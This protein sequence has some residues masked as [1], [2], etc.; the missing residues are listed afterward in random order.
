MK[1]RKN[2]NVVSSGLALTLLI[3]VG[4]PFQLYSLESTNT[5]VSALNGKVDLSYGN[6]DS[7][8]GHALGGS[9]SLPVGNAFGFQADGLYA[10]IDRIQLYGVGAHFFWRQNERGLIGLNVGFVDGEAQQSRQVAIETEYYWN[11]LTLAMMAG[12]SSI[13]YDN[14]A[15]FVDTDMEQFLGSV[16]LGYYAMDNLLITLGYENRFHQGSASLGAEY[17]LPLSGVSLYLSALKGE[18]DYEQALVGIRVAFGGGATL[19]QRHRNDDPSNM[20]TGILASIGNYGS[21]YY[22]KS[23]ESGYSTGE[24]DASF[25]QSS[26]NRTSKVPA[27]KT[28]PTG[29]P[30]TLPAPPPVPTI[31]IPTISVPPMPTLS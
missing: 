14:H 25:G 24:I 11:N 27:G 18:N 7:N 21:E 17:G 1:N 9:V 4:L 5:A 2:I 8:T 29:L 16:Q 20:L 10:N 6:Y 13:V 31:P 23:R 22:R 15:P 26:E 12:M 28:V 19:K 3:G 30:S